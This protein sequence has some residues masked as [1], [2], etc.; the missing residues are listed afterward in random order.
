VVVDNPVLAEELG[1]DG[2]GV[3]ERPFIMLRRDIPSRP[4]GGAIA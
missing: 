3:G 2:Y 4:F 1:C